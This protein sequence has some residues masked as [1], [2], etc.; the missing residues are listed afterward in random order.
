[1]V[2]LKSGKFRPEHLGQ[3]NFY[4]A[5]VN[6]MVRFPGMAPTVGILVCGP[7][8]ERTVRYALDGSSQPIAVTSYTYDALPAEEQAALPSPEAISAALEQG[9]VGEAEQE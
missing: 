2:E 8:K 1:M 4:V 5:A 6:D 3:L 9:T 7:K